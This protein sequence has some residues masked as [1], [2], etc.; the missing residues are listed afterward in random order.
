MTYEND[1]S[2][3]LIGSNKSTSSTVYLFVSVLHL[4]VG[5][6]EKMASQAKNTFE[7]P[8]WFVEIRIFW[9]R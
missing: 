8:K 2:R 1:S 5:R 6:E 7:I 9:Y 4:I 3:I